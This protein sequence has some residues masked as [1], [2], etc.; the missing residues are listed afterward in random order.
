MRRKFQDAVRPEV[1]A[2]VERVLGRTAR[3]FLSDHDVVR[4][5]GIEAILLDMGEGPVD[6]LSSS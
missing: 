5:V 2:L 3:A 4:D 6:E 1:V